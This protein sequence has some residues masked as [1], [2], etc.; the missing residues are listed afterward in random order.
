V[1]MG[2]LR[3]GMRQKLKWESAAIFGLDEKS[4]DLT[5]RLLFEY[6]F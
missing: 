6:E 4:P 3:W 1:I 5:L 2:E